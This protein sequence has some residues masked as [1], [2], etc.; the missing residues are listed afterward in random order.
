[1]VRLLR[2]IDGR[3]AQAFDVFAFESQVQ[4]L[5]ECFIGHMT[6]EQYW[7]EED[8]ELVREGKTVA[9][10]PFAGF[11][12]PPVTGLGEQLFCSGGVLSHTVAVFV[13][14]PEVGAAR[15]IPPITG[16]LVQLSGTRSPSTR[17]T[18]NIRFRLP[19]I[20]HSRVNRFPC[21]CSQSI[22][23]VPRRKRIHSRNLPAR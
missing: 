6:D 13:P 11:L 8:E 23:P 2:T 16:L 1:M 21:C 12:V 7:R 18:L 22:V 14:D 9:L 3:L 19:T 15:G 10:L 17:A 5:A 20:T 4:V